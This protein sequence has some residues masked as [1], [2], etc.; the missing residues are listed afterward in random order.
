ML[1]TTVM[2]RRSQEDGL[3]EKYRG[4]ESEKSLARGTGFDE[5][6]QVVFK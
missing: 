4:N 1:P 3:V 6:A 2:I 5:G